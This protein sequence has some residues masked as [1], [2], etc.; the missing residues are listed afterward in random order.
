[1]SPYMTANQMEFVLTVAL[2]PGEG[3]VS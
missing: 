3:T 2:H 1:M